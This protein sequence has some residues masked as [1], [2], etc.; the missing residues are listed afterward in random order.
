MIIDGKTWS[1]IGRSRN[2]YLCFLLM[3]GNGK[4][5]HQIMVAKILSGKGQNLSL[6]RITNEGIQY[7]S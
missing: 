5:W 2:R 1:S 7:E 6:G 3:A 4:E